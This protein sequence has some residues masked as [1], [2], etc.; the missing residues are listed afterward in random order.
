MSM[1]FS[2]SPASAADWTLAWPIQRAAFQALVDRSWGGWDAEHIQAC[3]DAWNPLQTR[4]IEV[5]GEMIGWVRAEHLPDH[6]W[7]DLIVVAPQ[8]QGQG[9]GSKV[10]QR[11]MAEAEARSVPLWLSVYRSNIARRLYARLGFAALERDEIR[12]FMVYPA[13]TPLLRPR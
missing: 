5:D 12:V 1:N 4:R 2:L 13:T 6:D 11:L 10:L 9:I 3:A 7:L 8:Y